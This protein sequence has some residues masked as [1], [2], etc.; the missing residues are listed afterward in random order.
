MVKKVTGV[1]GHLF[2]TNRNDRDVEIRKGM[3]APSTKQ[4]LWIDL[5]RDAADLKLV[6]EV[7]DWDGWL[8]HAKEGRTQP[9]IVNAEDRVRLSVIGIGKSRSHPNTVDVD[10][11]AKGN[12]VVTVHDGVVDGL[13]V[14]V[15]LAEDED[16]LGAFDAAE[17]TALM[18]DGVLSGYFHAVERIE[19]RIDDLDQRALRA[20]RDDRLIDQLVVLRGEISVL[21]RALGPQRQLFSSLER[22]GLVLGESDRAAWPLLAER[23]RE[24]VAAVENARELLVG[25]FDI[26]ISVTSQRTN[27]VMRMLTVISSV[28]LP[29]VVV[30]GVMGMNFKAEIFDSPQN[31]YFVIGAMIVLALAILG[32]ARWRGWL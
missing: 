27:D 10:V 23:Y 9:L 11:F 26:V 15:A 29:A 12:A 4:L 24:A 30:A 21:R 6:D 3:T 16:D 22:P 1:T 5:G 2:D 32:F 13:E 14:P 19:S 17:F 7:L 28:L 25:C 8:Q 18:L 31:F 20:S